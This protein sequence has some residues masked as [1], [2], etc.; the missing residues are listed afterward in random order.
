VQITT[1]NR[2]QTTARQQLLA[3]LKENERRNSRRAKE[4]RKV[5]DKVMSR[6]GAS[7][8]RTAG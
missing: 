3:F 6:A 8:Q 7:A 1:L 4:L 2:Q 5:A